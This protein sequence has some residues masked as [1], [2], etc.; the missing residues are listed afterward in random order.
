MTTVPL[1]RSGRLEC[2]LAPE[3][4]ALIQR[5]AAICGRSL[6]DYSVSRL[7]QAATQDIRQQET[8]VLSD[9][10][11]DIFFALLREDAEPNEAMK[12][13]AAHYKSRRV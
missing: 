12:R 2:R 8:T 6:T 9:R 13:A 3:A 4:K 5:A 10:D 7:I 1:Q 11:R